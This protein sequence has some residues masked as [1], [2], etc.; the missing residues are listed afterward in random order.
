MFNYL[1]KVSIT[2]SPFS[3]N[4][5]FGEGGGAIETNGTLNLVNVALDANHADMHN[6]PLPAGTAPGFGGA[7]LIIA[8][9]SVQISNTQFTNGIAGNSGGGIYND[10][11]TQVTITNSLFQGNQAKGLFA[12][13]GGYG[14][15]IINEG[16]LSLDN[17]TLASN[18]SKE[19]GGGL[20]TNVGV[21]VITGS[22]IT[23]NTSNNGGGIA[24]YS[25]TLTVSDTVVNGNTATQFG[26]GLLN[27]RAQTTLTRVTLTGNHAAIGGGF[28][29]NNAAGKV[30]LDTSGISGNVAGD[31]SAS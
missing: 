1:G 28:S 5:A 16:N 27:D 12:G 10:Q 18:T 21:A 4:Q 29:N 26:G 25:G 19:G 11:N 17:S 23:G 2:D 3:R 13:G 30:S 8:G 20:S 14:G 24:A 31:G 22:T 6:G 7:L 9:S 15:A